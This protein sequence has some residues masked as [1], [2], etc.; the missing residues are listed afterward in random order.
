[1]SHHVAKTPTPPL[2]DDGK[3]HAPSMVERG[4]DLL[5]PPLCAA[6]S[7]VKEGV[8]GMVSSA[9]SMGAAAHKKADDHK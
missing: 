9:R 8:H 4:A 2:K 6:A 3:E 7:L 5:F 1:M